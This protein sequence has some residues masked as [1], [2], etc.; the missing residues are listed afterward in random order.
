[1]EKIR[2]SYLKYIC[3]LLLFGLNGIVAS[4]VN[5]PSGEVVFLRTFIG[6]LTLGIIFFALKGKLSFFKHGKSVLFLAVS[7]AAMGI[8]WIFL[9]E[10]YSLI[11]VSFASLLYYC[12]PV[13]VMIFSTL[14]FKDKIT[15]SAI[16][17]FGIV[18]AGVFLVNGGAF[19]GALNG[20]GVFCGVISAFMYSVMVICG[21][22][23]KGIKGLEMSMI[24]L[25]LSFLTITVFMGIKRGI[26]INLTDLN[27]LPVLVLGILNTGIGCYLYFS[28]INQLPVRT[29]AVVGYAEP[30]SAVIFA[31]MLLGE[32]L[33]PVQIM[34]AAFI[35]GGALYSELGA[36]TKKQSRV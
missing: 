17:G 32:R 33:L 19:G 10:A 11:G 25:I 22:K 30:L 35:I 31:S 12:G 29:V 14:I 3:A 7:G 18:L 24:Q 2:K 6:S 34:G 5:L 36:Y 9:F 21:K 20:R 23:A 4:F 8:S 28:S 27:L 26:N 16:L 15:K 1:M 13:I